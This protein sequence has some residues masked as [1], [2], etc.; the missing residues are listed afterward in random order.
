MIGGGSDVRKVPFMGLRVNCFFGVL[1]GGV[2]N[3]P[4]S[5]SKG[6]MRPRLTTAGFLKV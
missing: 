5:Q 1:G 6:V 2:D 4:A 3:T